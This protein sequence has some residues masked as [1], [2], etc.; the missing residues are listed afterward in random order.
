MRIR[1]NRKSIDFRRW[2]EQTSRNAPLGDIVEL[3]NTAIREGAELK[4]SKEG[5]LQKTLKFAIPTVI[6]FDPIVGGVVS[7]L[8][9][10]S[11]FV[12]DLI[13]STYRPSIFIENYLKKE[14]DSK[15]NDHKIRSEN[16]Y[17]RK[18]HGVIAVNSQCPCGS[19][20]KYKKCHGRFR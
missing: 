2:L 4:V 17:Y 16:D 5:K 3:Y 6:G 15:M 10:A 20:K 19:G 7:P 8:I 12:H 18:E 9:S 14:I 1:N 13:K 11:L